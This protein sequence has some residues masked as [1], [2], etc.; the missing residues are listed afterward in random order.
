MPQ[1]RNN[2]LFDKH[3]LALAIGVALIAVLLSANF[4]SFSSQDRA[5]VLRVTGS[6]SLERAGEKIAPAA[7]MVLNDRDRLSTEADSSLEVTY[8]DGLKNIIRIGSDSNVML[9]NAIIE[10]QTNIYLDRGDVILKLEKLEKGSSFK[11]RTPTAVAGVRGTSFGV[12]LIGKEAE[13]LDY[14]SRI[15]VKG[16]NQ[17]FLENQEELLLN[18]G[19]KVRL[20]QFEKPS[21]VYRIS[22]SERTEWMNWVTDIAAITPNLPKSSKFITFKPIISVP[23][24]GKYTVSV[25]ESAFSSVL[26]HMVSSI[27]FLAF[28]LFVALSINI[29]RILT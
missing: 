16:L 4:I 25:P 21:R 12:R 8:D 23:V 10:K 24:F 27:S 14:D 26:K 20:T 11:V 7:G 18:E 29:A 2:W 17:D 19:W 9:E 13:I 15:F 5:R 6:V 3:F 22:E 1:S 28:V